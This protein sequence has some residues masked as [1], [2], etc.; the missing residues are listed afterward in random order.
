M[1]TS[2][3]PVFADPTDIGP[4]APVT[5]AVHMPEHLH[6][7]LVRQ[8]QELNR[9]GLKAYGLLAG[10][11]RQPGF[12]YRAV[13]V[14]VL[15][16]RRNRRNDPAHRAA[17]HA[18]GSYF[19]AYEDAGFVADPTNLLHTWQR[20]ER[21]GLEPVAAF[22]VH[23]RQ[24]ANFSSI[25]FRLHNPAFAWHLIISLRDPA[26]P[27]V[28]PFLVNK[29]PDQLGIEESDDLEGSELPY[30]GPEV[31]AST[32]VVIPDV[33]PVLRGERQV[34]DAVGGEAA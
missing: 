5:P 21:A 11:P 25:D 22:H 24:P 4:S 12:P 18:Q 34:L 3:P 14:V 17:F 19:R 15:D 6:S 29:D 16:P 13:D 26:R 2:V 9:A 8:A 23:R 1:L 31:T 28:R 10:D 33:R 20:I 27:D 30:S 32:L 7:R